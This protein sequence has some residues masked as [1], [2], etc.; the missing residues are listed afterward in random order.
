MPDLS[1]IVKIMIK[2]TGIIFLLF[3]VI[4]AFPNLYNRIILESLNKKVDVI[5]DI[6]VLEEYTL[7]EWVE[8]SFAGR[9]RPGLDY[10]FRSGRALQYKNVTLIFNEKNFYKKA[11]EVMKLK[12][13]GRIET[14]KFNGNYYIRV[15]DTDWDELQEMGMG[16]IKMEDG[17]RKMEGG[18][19]KTKGDEIARNDVYIRPVNDKWVNTAYINWL[20][21]KVTAGSIIFKGTEVMGFPDNIEAVKK[22]IKKKN[23]TV[24]VI[25]F[26]NQKGF[27]QLSKGLKVARLFS[28]GS[29]DI[30]NKA[31]RGVRERNI[32]VIYLKNSKPET[33]EAIREKLKKNGFLPGNPTGLDTSENKNLMPLFG[34]I[35]AL[36]GLALICIGRASSVIPLSIIMA[37]STLFFPGISLQVLTILSAICFPLAAT[38]IVMR[39][40]CNFTKGIIIYFVFSIMAGSLIGSAAAMPSFFVKLEQLRCIKIALIVPLILSIFIVYKNINFKKPVIWEEILIFLTLIG[41]AGICVLRSSNNQI[42]IV[43]DLEMKLRLLL[44]NI[45]IFRPRFKEFLFGHPLLIAG[46]YFFKNKN[47]NFR[48]LIIPG[49]TGQVSIINTFM[50]IHTPF[51]VSVSRTLCGILLGV[52]AGAVLIAVI[53]KWQELRK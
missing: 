18:S 53:N 42:G 20:F 33:A 37:G 25:E 52:S 19:W 35:I 16:I 26:A 30:V 3:G 45:F 13:P 6:N 8:K 5:S 34:M 23:M 21:S 24:F 14:V 51:M 9:W 44:E 49:L 31:V 47:K 38:E 43:S 15:M 28:A 41:I 40:N 29:E 50:H 27:K 11:C 22:W 1:G 32:R 7:N 4:L 2:K 39:K 17:R 48:I 46:L 36:T 10:P 12:L